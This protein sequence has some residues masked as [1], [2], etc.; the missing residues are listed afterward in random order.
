MFEQH[1]ELLCRGLNYC[2]NC[3]IFCTKRNVISWCFLKK[4]LINTTNLC[5]HLLVLQQ[6]VIYFLNYAFKKGFQ[7]LMLHFYIPFWWLPTHQGEIKQVRTES[8]N[9]YVNKKHILSIQ[10]KKMLNSNNLPCSCAAAPGKHFFSPSAKLI[11][12]LHHNYR[13]QIWQ[14]F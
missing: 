9:E 12:C 7:Y 11:A 14:L 10:C 13:E 8:A 2:V 5:L 6:G 3:Y 4:N 1:F